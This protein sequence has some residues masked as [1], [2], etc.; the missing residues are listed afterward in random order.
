MPSCCYRP[1]HIDRTFSAISRGRSVH[2]IMYMSVSQILGNSTAE[3][4]N[5]TRELGNFTVELRNFTR[6]LGALLTESR[7]GHG[8]PLFRT[9]AENVRK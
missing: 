8:G 9:F 2:P 6:E 3:L 1:R 4:G 7:S 5:F